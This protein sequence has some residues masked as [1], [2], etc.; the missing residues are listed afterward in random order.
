MR[1]ELKFKN[2]NDVRSELNRLAQGP[3]ETTSVWSYYQIL[4]HCATVIE[5]TMKGIEPEMTWLHKYV[6]G[7]S[8]FRKNAS[9]GSIPAG[10]KGRPEVAPEKREEGDEKAALARLHKAM[11]DFERFE[12]K[13]SLHRRLGKLKKHQWI[14][15][16][17]MHTAN[18]IG[19]AKLKD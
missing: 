11:D 9:D 7:P 15:F 3:V 4:T 14:H 19:Y 5:N 13:F 12:G 16:H 17:A 8:F 2:L 18:H 10:I 1:R 6:V